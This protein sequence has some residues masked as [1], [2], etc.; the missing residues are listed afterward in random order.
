MK[1]GSRRMA[2]YE[3]LSPRSLCDFQSEDEENQRL[4]NHRRS[5]PVGCPSR[6]FLSKTRHPDSSSEIAASS[7][8]R[9]KNR[10]SIRNRCGYSRVC[11]LT[12]TELFSWQTQV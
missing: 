6:Y 11:P 10:Q 1:A 7:L 3:P 4:A 2:L 5:F 12:P 8:G 9:Y